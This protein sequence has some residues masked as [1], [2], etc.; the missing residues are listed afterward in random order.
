[1]SCSL[2][3]SNLGCTLEKGERLSHLLYADDILLLADNEQDLEAEIDIAMNELHKIGFQLSGRKCSVYSHEF[4]VG[5]LSVKTATNLKIADEP[6]RCVLDGDQIEYLGG[7][8]WFEHTVDQFISEI[9]RVFEQELLR[10]PHYLNDGVV[11]LPLSRGGL[12]F[13]SIKYDVVNARCLAYNEVPKR[14]KILANLVR[15]TGTFKGI[16]DGIPLDA[17]LQ[18]VYNKR[19]FLEIL[20]QQWRNAQTQAQGMS[21]FTRGMFV[22]SMLSF[23]YR[24]DSDRQYREAV[25]LRFQLLE[26]GSVQHLV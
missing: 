17:D 1:M 5:R 15:T 22:R 24:Q 13:R 4:V 25:K 2:D 12:G 18:L 26:V 21:E 9:D 10:L 19:D 23:R 11:F 7:E 3:A 20:E 6:V 16:H 14:S 8:P